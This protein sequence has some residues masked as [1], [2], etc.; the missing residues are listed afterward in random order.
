[1]VIFH[2]YVSLP[3][4][5]IRH[6]IVKSIE[7]HISS[8]F[9]LTPSMSPCFFCGQGGLKNPANKE[10]KPPISSKCSSTLIGGLI[11]GLM[12][13][14]MLI[15]LVMLWDLIPKLLNLGFGIQNY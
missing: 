2:S 3:E 4:G 11:G 1:M 6:F 8:P 14:L 12:A 10:M 15:Y 13:R 9:L 7:F 5:K